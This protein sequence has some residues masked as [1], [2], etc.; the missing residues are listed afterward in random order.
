MCSAQS[1]CSS[2][3]ART[4][5]D[6]TAVPLF[7]KANV[8]QFLDEDPST[9]EVSSCN[10][11]LANSSCVYCG[12]TCR[13][14]PSTGTVLSG[15]I[16]ECCTQCS[17]HGT[18]LVLN[19]YFFACLERIQFEMWRSALFSHGNGATRAGIVSRGPF[20]QRVIVHRP[21]FSWYAT[22]STCSLLCS[23][24]WKLSQI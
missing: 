20:N 23:K 18:C 21:S 4:L 3:R 6:A 12:G 24:A 17:T 15:C 10:L 13:E 9:L 1:T 14:L 22:K 16:Q 2:R 8:K 11:C 19:F 5:H 7:S